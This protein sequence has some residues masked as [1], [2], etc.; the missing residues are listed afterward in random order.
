MI[1]GFG[2][3]RPLSLSFT[4]SAAIQVLGVASGVL[5]ARVLGPEARGELAAVLLWPMVIV[6]AGAA[7]VTEAVAYYAARDRWPLPTLAATTLGIALAL[8]VVLTGIGFGAISL[9]LAG[10]DPDVRTAGYVFLANVP[11]AMVALGAAYLL[12]G[13]H[14]FVWFNAIRVLVVGASAVGLVALAVADRLTVMNATVAYLVGT[15]V[16]LIVAVLGVWRVVGRLGRWSRR[17][18]GD[19]LVFGAKGQLSTVSNVLNERV[20]QLVISVAL[21]PEKLGLY[22]VAWTLAT[23]IALIGTSIGFTALPVVAGGRT[24]PDRAA[25]ACRYVSL[26]AVFSGA[27]AVP[28]ALLAP[29]VIDLFFGGRFAG[30]SESARVLIV[31]GALLGVGRALGAV[32]KGAGRP[33]DA[34]VA[35]LIGLGVTAV[36]LGVLLPMI[37]I[38]GAAITSLVA[39]FASMAYA[40]RRASRALGPG[41]RDFLVPASGTVAASL[42]RLFSV[43]R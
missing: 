37:G 3:N 41:S 21:P 8:S 5:L 42:R 19:V 39:Y 36:G 18:A 9:A 27:I 24:A 7:G 34:G 20:D 32:L 30:A 14:R 38:L 25:A 23:P 31:A 35:E 1:R 40:L 10:Q 12:N 6:A 13:L 28:L 43:W 29:I 26:A 15:L 16:T 2:V 4:A 11:L 17:V 33:L 22:V